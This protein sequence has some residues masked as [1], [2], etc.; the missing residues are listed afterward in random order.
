MTSFIASVLLVS[1]TP[2]LW[3]PFTT[4]DKLKW[5]GG[6]VSS[7]AYMV[8]N[9]RFELTIRYRARSPENP[10][11]SSMD[12]LSTVPKNLRKAPRS[13][14]PLSHDAFVLVNDESSLSM[15]AIQKGFSISIGVITRR[16]GI[17]RGTFR[18]PLPPEIEAQAEALARETSARRIGM[19]LESQ[20]SVSLAGQSLP[21]RRSKLSGVDFV[22]LTE[23]AQSVGGSIQENDE[24]LRFTL[25]KG[26]KVFQF[27]WGTP[28]AKMGGGWEALP[29]GVALRNGQLWIPLVAAQRF[30]SANN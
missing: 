2:Q 25:G 17:G 11:Q 19:E 7:G 16:E 18:R 27:A 23:F 20:S 14:V 6:Q 13:E 12:H 5:E 30:L 10:V 28:Y 26:S 22:P 24:T 15:L 9:S 29:D 4:L 1:Q 3:V 8:K 21:R